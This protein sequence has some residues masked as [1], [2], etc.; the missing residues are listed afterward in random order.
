M[1]RYFNLS[2]EASHQ[3][4]AVICTPWVAVHIA[5]RLWRGSSG[6]V[7]LKH[8]AVAFVVMCARVM[9]ASISTYSSEKSI[10]E[11]NHDGN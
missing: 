8:L 1:G 5:G 6:A 7:Q 9:C 3:S 2:L 11:K 4:C 10:R